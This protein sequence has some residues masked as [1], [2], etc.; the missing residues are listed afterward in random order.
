MV[1]CLTS[2]Q[3][4]RFRVPHRAPKKG[5]VA[6]SSSGR[7]PDSDSGDRGSTPCPASSISL[8]CQEKIL[9]Q[10]KST[11]KNIINATLINREITLEKEERKDENGL[12]KF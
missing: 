6:G 12:M 9:L 2:N 4:K 11:E 1:I 7:T 5:N 3:E 10:I 8:K